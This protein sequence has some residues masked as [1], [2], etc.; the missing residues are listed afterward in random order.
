MRAQ[1]LALGILLA[2]TLTSVGCQGGPSTRALGI[3][4]D[5][6]MEAGN[7]AEAAEYY[8][9][10]VERRPIDAEGRY[11]LA[12]AY[13]GAERPTLAREQFILGLELR[14]DGRFIEGAA[15]ALVEIGQQEELFKL[16][17][18]KA[19]TTRSIEDYTRLGRFAARV[20]DVDEAEQALLFAA[21]L[22]EGQNVEPQLE[23]ARF[24]ESL[25]DDSRRLER[26]RMVLFLDPENTEAIQGI[27]DLGEVPGPAY[28][29]PP[30]EQG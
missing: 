13:L 27:T 25:G 29:I 18:N 15:D 17:R 11:K 5:R 2:L 14:D 19:E 21:K 24:Y 8:E 20:G 7:Y 3:Y 28:A 12:T 1:A 30:A 9:K 10:Y 16:L 22:D 23:L 26:L 4:G 6:A